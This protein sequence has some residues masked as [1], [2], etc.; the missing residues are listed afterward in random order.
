MK[1]GTNKKTK[2]DGKQPQQQQQELFQQYKRQIPVPKQSHIIIE[3]KAKQIQDRT[4][5]TLIIPF[6]KDPNEYITVRGEPN[7]VQAA[8]KEINSMIKVNNNTD[9]TERKL[10]V[11]KV[12][13]RIVI[14]KQGANIN[15][16]REKFG[17]NVIV[18]K[19]ESPDQH[20]IIRG[21]LQ[22]IEAAKFD[23]LNT[24]KDTSP[25]NT[26]T[27]RRGNSPR[28]RRDDT[29]GDDDADGEG[30]YGGGR[31]EGG[32]GGGRSRQGA[33][34]GSEGTDKD[35]KS[36]TTTTTFEN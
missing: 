12:K 27:K 5:A 6:P 28:P 26:T 8:I 11:A 34:R 15:R 30:G 16:I 4:G 14:G 3:E 19:P 17:V 33:G 32:E 13:H 7:E 29:R 31:R 1:I 20:I 22:D 36:T 21:N 2:K 9:G 18:P 23:I 25:E 10:F 24:L 35:K